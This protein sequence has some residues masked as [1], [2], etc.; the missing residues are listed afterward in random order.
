MSD[1]RY[2][3]LK[4]R[5]EQDVLIL[6]VTESNLRGDETAEALY[7]EMLAAVDRT[8]IKQVVLDLGNAVL[9]SSV[10]FRPLL[11]LRRKLKEL[12]GRMV[13]CNL[14]H[15]LQEIFRST[16]LIT[17]HGSSTPPFEAYPDVETAIAALKS[18][19]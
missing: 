17:S 14:S 16:R 13:L 11:G 6:S 15:A 12:G 4:I 8:G 10:A 2:R 3:H 5:T 1:F 19:R 18:Y 9:F 7:L